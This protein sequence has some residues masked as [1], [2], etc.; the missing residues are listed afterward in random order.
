MTPL[1]FLI[2]CQSLLSLSAFGSE[3]LSVLETKEAKSEVTG[4]TIVSGTIDLPRKGYWVAEGV[5]RDQGGLT[6]IYLTAEN[7]SPASDGER[8]AKLKDRSAIQ[9][10]RSEMQSIYWSCRKL[11]LDGSGLAPDSL[12]GLGPSYAASDADPITGLHLIPGVRMLKKEGERMV[13]VEEA[14]PLLIDATPAIDD[15]KHWVLDN[16]GGA[17]RKDL[18]AAWLKSLDLTIAPQAKSHLGRLGAG[19]ANLTY[20]VY[21]RRTGAPG[22]SDF[23][24]RNVSQDATLEI[25]WDTSK[26]AQGGDEIVNGWANLRLDYLSAYL[27]PDATASPHWA[28]RMSAQY[29][30]DYDYSEE[31][32]GG[33]GRNPGRTVSAMGVIGG[34]AAIRETLQRQNI[35]SDEKSSRVPEIPIGEIPGV[36]V[37]AHPFEE[38]LGDEPGG[39]LP[40]A[41]WIPHDHFLLYLPKPDGLFD[42]LD[43]SSGFLFNSGTT[44]TGRSG[45]HQIKDRYLESFGVSETLMR[46]FLETGA[47]QEI[48]ATV[49][50]LFLIDGTEISVVLRTGRPVLTT[51]ALALVG[52]PPGDGTTVKKNS[53]G[54]S[55]YWVRK[56][57]ILIISTHQKEV[58]AILAAKAEDRGLG[59]SAELRY[60]LTQVPVTP[61]TVVYSYFSDPFIRHLVGPEAKIGQL[62]RLHARAEL[63]AASAGALLARFDGNK[64]QVADLKFLAE[65]K[66]LRP[67]QTVSDLTLK[68]S[69]ASSSASYGSPRHMHSL[70]R[71]PVALASQ[72]EREAYGEYLENYNRFWRQFFDPIA[73]RYEQKPGGHH[74]L[75]T[76]ILPLVD[77]TLY[78]GI[79]QFVPS[80]ESSIPLQV[81]VLTPEPIGILSANLNDDAWL[82]AIENFSEA[83]TQT[84]GLDGS[85]LDLLGPDVHIAVHDADPIISIG[86]GEL[87]G[88]FGAFGGST[89]SEMITLPAAVSMLTRPSTI[90]IGLSDPEEVRRILTSSARN[91]GGENS[92]M[93]F[94]EGSLAKVTG[95]DK[96]IYRL[97]IEDVITLRYGIEVQDRYLVISNLPFSNEIKVT[98]SESASNNAVALQLN[99]GA[100]FKQLPALFSSTAEANRNAVHSATACLMP[101]LL[102]GEDDPAEAQASHARIFGFKPLHPGGGSW[103]W[104]GDKSE[105]L[106]SSYDSIWTNQQPAFDP[107]GPQAGVLQAVSR[108][109]F[110]MQFEQDGLRTTVTWKTK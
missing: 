92:I 94:A 27:R 1:P 41:D 30:L 110:A 67:A 82:G 17:T 25:S 61:E 22:K 6:E 91:F 2:L 107:Q 44:V 42:L 85:V 39:R 73:I 108:A 28:A 23:T 79:R 48:A 4:V 96:W 83:L 70:T 88:L 20:Q 101:F 12:D 84:L 7:H 49:P 21:A 46:R 26:P 36:E 24:I 18:D 43:S 104:D 47:I 87:A 63:E 80:E 72:S 74:E 40:L 10:R 51:V 45:S 3:P 64:D 29:K 65:H 89:D 78:Q 38:M 59:Q 34:R 58:D 106:S 8:S 55:V 97:S 50:D 66:Y 56:G 62:R 11:A 109:D 76:F 19:E 54:E 60:M 13:R 75:E 98:G 95:E 5:Y 103:S 102:A 52:V 35:I 71:N 33:N 100:C 14:T 57:D 93:D 69:L 53:E 9:S 99:P 16:H 81:P 31:L 15:G 32:F 68:E 37:K 77:N 90:H 86:N 105:L